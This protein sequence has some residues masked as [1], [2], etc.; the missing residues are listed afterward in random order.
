MTTHHTFVDTRDT[1][2]MIV[3]PD[4]PTWD[5]AR[6]AWNKAIDQH[7]AAVALP[8]SAEDVSAVI[9]YAR[10]RG[11]R[12]AAQSTGHNAGPL[13]PLADTVLVKTEAMRGVQ[14]D[15][16]AGTMRVEAGVWVE[17]V[18]AAARHGLAALAGSSPNVGWPAT[19]SGVAWAGSDAATGCRVTTSGPSRWSPLT[20]ACCG[21]MQAPSRTCSG[22]YAAVAQ[23]RRGHRYRAAAL[24]DQPGPCR[25]PVVA[26]RAWPHPGSPANRQPSVRKQR[27]VTM[28]E[29]PTSASAGRR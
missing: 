22:R 12:V 23:L 20:A 3:L 15:P 17:V 8:R 27:T 19:S 24:P 18:E 10:Q 29:R 2:G 11:L 4:D 13:G 6:Q 21:S 26:D 14:V 5:E 1:P 28:I 25:H 16:A 9:D 7:P